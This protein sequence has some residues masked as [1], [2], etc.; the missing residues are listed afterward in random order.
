MNEKKYALVTGGNKG[1]GFATVREL[2]S[3]NIIVY[4][5]S[6][7]AERGEK[8]VKELSAGKMDVRPVRLDVTDRATIDKAY[9]YI[10]KDAGRLNILINNA[11]ITVGPEEQFTLEGLRR[12]YETNVFGL[13]AVTRAFLPLLEAGRPSRILN[14]SSGLG[15]LTQLAGPSTGGG[16]RYGYFAYGSSKT[17]VNALTAYLGEEL[18]KSGITVLSIAPGFT[19]TDLN[20]F[21]GINP[22]EHAARTIVKYA[23]DKDESKTGGFFDENGR[24]PW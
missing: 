4:L 1:I 18:K 12:V 19:A 5:G 7:D 8:A 6:R 14:I 3:H 21:R 17:T 9:E 16:T 10:K 15:S 2:T 24:V 22:P 23:L 13:Y 20:N 11:G